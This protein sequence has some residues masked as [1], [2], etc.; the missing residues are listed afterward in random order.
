MN[1]MPQTRQTVPRGLQILACMIMFIVVGLTFVF[2][3]E[4]SAYYREVQRERITADMNK[5]WSAVPAA[6]YFHLNPASLDPKSLITNSPK[7]IVSLRPE[8][9]SS[10][11]AVIEI[12]DPVAL[13]KMK[14][15]TMRYICPAMESDR[16][17]AYNKN[18]V[19]STITIYSR[20]AGGNINTEKPA[21]SFLLDAMMLTPGHNFSGDLLSGMSDSDDKLHQEAMSE[22]YAITMP[23]SLKPA[24]RATTETDVEL[25]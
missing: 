4:N 25:P 20:D 15:W 14:A 17:F 7:M 24:K 5:G 13:E 22:L 10:Q 18:S 2:T 19:G 11:N 9:Y 12:T 6:T 23:L 21:A 3:F 16:Q 1:N 8:H